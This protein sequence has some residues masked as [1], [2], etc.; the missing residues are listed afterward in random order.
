MRDQIVKDW[1]R[2]NGLSNWQGQGFLGDASSRQYQRLIGPKGQSVIIMDAPTD[3]CGSQTSFVRIAKHLTANGFAAPDII[4]WDD[5]LGLMILSDLG[6]TDVAA[7]ISAHPSD[8][9]TLYEV[10]TD[11]LTHLSTIPPLDGLPCMTPTVGAKMLDPAFDW[12]AL[13]DSITLRQDITSILTALLKLVDPA[14]A[15]L[16]LRDFHAENLIWRPNQ[17][18]IS[19]MGLLDFQDAFIT[20]PTYDLASLIRDARRNGPDHLLDS[21]LL[22]L[23][24]QADQDVQRRAFHVMAVQRNL[25][26]LGIFQKLAQSDGKTRYLDFVPRVK[27]YLAHDLSAPAL[28]DLKPL[29]YRAFLDGRP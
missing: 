2:K 10:A 22:R 1:L 6:Q 5:T 3:T 23:D 11:V 20:H 17:S 27:S 15:T 12:A 9:E 25:R 8:D 19:R 18:G 14:P 4:E 26:I 16:S 7:Y 24:P 29:I 28:A 13:D 21:L